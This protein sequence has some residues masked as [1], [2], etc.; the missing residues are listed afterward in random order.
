[1]DEPDPDSKKIRL[2]AADAQGA[3]ALYAHLNQIIK[4]ATRRI[5]EGQIGFLNPTGMH[6]PDLLLAA[7]SFRA[8]LFDADGGPILLDFLRRHQI[9]MEL[10]AIETNAGMILM[11]LLSLEGNITDVLAEILLDA[12]KLPPGN[13]HQMLFVYDEEGLAENLE[14]RSPLWHPT[15]EDNEINFP[16]S[17]TNITKQGASSTKGLAQLVD[18]KHHRVRPELWGDV[19]IGFLK[20]RPIRRRNL[21]AYVANKLGGVH[22][23]SRRF[24]PDKNDE[25]EFRALASMYDP[26]FKAI[27]HGGLVATGMACLE[28]AIEP[29]IHELLRALRKFLA[30]RPN[31][32][33]NKG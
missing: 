18:I 1:M 14:S 19:R 27:M 25:N 22:L 10:S 33:L 12:E 2:K 13:S 15:K 4:T 3:L 21:L 29:Q 26:D 23:D 17:L 16:P 30:D 7:A 9:S 8:L 24:P 28:F 11:P 32:V 5:P 6:P 31:R 20:D